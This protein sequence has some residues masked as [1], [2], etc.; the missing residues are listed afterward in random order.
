M[1]VKNLDD[2]HHVFVVALAS[3]AGILLITNVWFHQSAHPHST[4][5]TPTESLVPLSGP[6]RSSRSSA[7]SA[8]NTRLRIATLRMSRRG[9]RPTSSIASG[10]PSKCVMERLRFPLI[11]DLRS[12]KVVWGV[13][14]LSSSVVIERV[15][16]PTC[17]RGIG[18][19]RGRDAHK[20]ARRCS[21][22]LMNAVP[23]WVIRDSKRSSSDMGWSSIWRI[24]AVEYHGLKLMK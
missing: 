17:V 23:D 20:S 24:D 14:R 2:D 9:A 11:P 10:T 7:L 22:T 16:L 18:C 1:H 15:D 4:L 5:F 21:T 8:C 13:H 6:L 19:V 3:I 12:D